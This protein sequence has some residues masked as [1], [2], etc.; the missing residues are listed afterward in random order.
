[1]P[2]SSTQFIQDTYSRPYRTFDTDIN[3]TAT[4]SGALPYDDFVLELALRITNSPEEAE[5]A[6]QEMN[7]DIRRTAMGPVLTLRQRLVERI[8]MTRL[9]NFLR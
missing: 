8:A 3:E 2:I 5:A 4:A 7:R 6:V 1:M 9:I